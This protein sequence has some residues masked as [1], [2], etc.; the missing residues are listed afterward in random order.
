[1]QLGSFF[2]GCEVIKMGGGGARAKLFVSE[3]VSERVETGVVSSLSL[4][5]GRLSVD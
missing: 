2:V 1:M 4:T 3:A 5:D